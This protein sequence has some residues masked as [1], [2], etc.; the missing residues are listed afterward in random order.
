MFLIGQRHLIRLNIHRNLSWLR[1]E[2]IWPIIQSLF[3]PV[4]D[5][6][7]Y[8]DLQPQYLFCIISSGLV[9]GKLCDRTYDSSGV[10][11]LHSTHM[12]S[13]SIFSVFTIIHCCRGLACSTEHPFLLYWRD[14]LPYTRATHPSKHEV[15]AQCWADVGPSSTT[16]GQHQPT[17]GQRLVFSGML[18]HV[19][20]MKD[21]QKADR[22]TVSPP[23]GDS[24]ALTARPCE[25][26][27]EPPGSHF[28]GPPFAWRST[29]RRSCQPDGTENNKGPGASDDE[30]I[31]YLE[32]KSDLW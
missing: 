15:L 27:E 30:T 17:L 16:V 5:A 25:F 1:L 11:M 29:S 21:S 4:V 32:A 8:T 23:T 3:E 13:H 22:E 20:V 14:T 6:K 24:R 28:D 12:C 19:F 10:L 7:F 9:G 2:Y 18:R 31:W 26:R